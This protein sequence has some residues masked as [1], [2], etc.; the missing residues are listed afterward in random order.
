MTTAGDG[1]KGEYLGAPPKDESE[2]FEV[3]PQ[4]GQAVDA[5]DLNQVLHHAQPG[6]K[7][8]ATDA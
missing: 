6:H 5:R 4:C 7:P 2:H 1:I 8:T 3:C